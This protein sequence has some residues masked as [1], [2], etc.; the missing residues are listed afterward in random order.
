MHKRNNSTHEV[1]PPSDSLAELLEDVCRARQGEIRI[2]ADD[3]VADATR[4][5]ER[6][7]ELDDATVARGFAGRNDRRRR[8]RLGVL[9]VVD[10]DVERVEACAQGYDLTECRRR[11]VEMEA[12][13][14]RR[15]RGRVPEG[16]EE[17][18]GMAG[19]AEDRMAVVDGRCN[20]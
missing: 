20:A 6:L 15:E 17:E 10:G 14:A 9:A 16:A 5:R 2:L 13:D 8:R 4:H 11:R 19:R 3:E 1:L 12:A 18:L 7:A